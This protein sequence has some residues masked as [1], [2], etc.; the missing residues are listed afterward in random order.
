MY[1]KQM[2]VNPSVFFFFF[3]LCTIVIYIFFCTKVNER[4]SPLEEKD[5]FSI[6]IMSSSDSVLFF[7]LRFR[8]DR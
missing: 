7:T 8:F 3:Y 5:R 1:L 6:F 2:H 4:I